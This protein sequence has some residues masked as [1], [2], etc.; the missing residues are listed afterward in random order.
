M[1]DVEED[2]LAAEMTRADLMVAVHAEFAAFLARHFSAEAECPENA[3]SDI[4]ALTRSLTD[5]AGRRGDVNAD[6][7]TRRIQGAVLG[8]LRAG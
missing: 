4:M 6:A 3:A 2:R 5:G 8:Y 1:L 7:L